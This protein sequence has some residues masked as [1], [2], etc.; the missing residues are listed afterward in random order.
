MGREIGFVGVANVFEGR[1][2]ILRF[3]VLKIAVEKKAGM[4]SSMTY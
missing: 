2:R 4:D 3:P 1:P